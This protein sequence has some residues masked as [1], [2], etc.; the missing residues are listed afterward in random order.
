MARQIF[1]KEKVDLKATIYFIIDYNIDITRKPLQ[2]YVY[3]HYKKW[4][5]QNLTSL[6]ACYSLAIYCTKVLHKH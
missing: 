6:S 5:G 2:L 1:T 3:D 4:P